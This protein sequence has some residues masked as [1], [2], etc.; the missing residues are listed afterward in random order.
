M[1]VIRK[2]EKTILA[3]IL[4]LIAPILGL[5]AF[6]WAA[7]PLLPEKWI[8]F[9]ALAGLLLG[10]GVDVVFLKRWVRKADK[11][12][13]K[14]WMAIHLFYTVGIFGMFMGVPVVN[15]LLSIP[16]GFVIGGK[17]A[18]ENADLPLVRKATCATAWF[19]TIILFLICVSSATLA[20][21]DPTTGANLQGMFSLGFEV[22]QEMIV[23]LIL[24]GGLLLLA[25]NWALTAVTV[26]FSHTFLKHQ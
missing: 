17:L 24:V 23:G 15:A 12:S 9:T 13:V 10:I 2:L 6:W 7:L 18:V 21:L 14:L 1:T 26:R 3:L 22:T 8:P 11:F 16:A 5:L 4:G 19:T 25:F 20:L